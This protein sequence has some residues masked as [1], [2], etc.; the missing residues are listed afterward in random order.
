MKIGIISDTHDRCDYIEW[1]LREFERERIEMLIHLGDIVAPF[2]AKRFATI[3]RIPCPRRLS[4]KS[5][6]VIFP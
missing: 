1:F 3:A 6:K 2:A 4:S 5:S